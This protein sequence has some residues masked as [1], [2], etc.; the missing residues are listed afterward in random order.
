MLGAKILPPEFDLQRKQ[1]F[2]I[3]LPDWLKKGPWRD[4]FYDTLQNNQSL[5]DKRIT[6]ELLKGQDMGKKNSER[7]FG[8]VIFELWRQEYKI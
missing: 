6:N 1:G 4:L 5:F 3:P 8:L 7:L 2:S